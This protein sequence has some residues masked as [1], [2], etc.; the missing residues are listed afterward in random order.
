[1]KKTLT[2][3]TSINAPRRVVWDKTLTDETYRIWTAP[4]CEGSYFEGS[5]DQ[6]SKMKFLSPSGHGMTSVIAENRPYEYLSIEHIGEIVNGVE[7]TS[8][9]KV[10]QWAPA[11]E[12]YSF[13][14]ADGGT[15]L[16]VTLDTIPDLEQYMLDTFPKALNV[17]K[18][19]C[20]AEAKSKHA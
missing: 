13:A 14:D 6:G 16:T 3:S 11:Y 5:W 20:E 12:N 10:K 2:F 17:L 1:M 7:D 18:E 8:S 19:L 15:A 9:D 4:F